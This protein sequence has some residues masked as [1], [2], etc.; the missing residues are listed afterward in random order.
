MFFRI[1][2]SDINSKQNISYLQSMCLKNNNQKTIN[3]S[4]SAD[5]TPTIKYTYIKFIPHYWLEA[6]F[7]NLIFV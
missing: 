5:S 3:V 7:I 1:I 6:S 2:Q 4:E